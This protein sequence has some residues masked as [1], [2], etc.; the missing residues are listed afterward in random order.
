MPP[1]PAANKITEMTISTTSSGWSRRIFLVCATRLVCATSL[2]FSAEPPA[3]L[4]RLAAGRETATAAARA[5]YTYKQQVLFEELSKNGVRVGE[6]KELREVIFSPSGERTEQMTGK[7]SNSLVRIKLTDEDFRDMREVQPMLLTTETLRLYQ[8]EQRGEEK[9]GNL[10]CWVLSIRPRQILDGQRLFEGLLWIEKTSFSTIRSEGRA[11]PQI[12]KKKE[13][14][15]FP[16]FTTIRLEMEGGF[17]FPA[18]TFSDDTLPFASGPIR[19]RIRIT[20]SGYKRFT[21]DSSIKFGAE[22][23]PQ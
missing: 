4:V 12:F 7:P 10:D 3:N 8:V 14:N 2:A 20:Y 9:V 23:I 21:A 16:R 17:W 6:Y 5:N 11:M 22:A 19:Q 15:L 1:K 13:E 18:V